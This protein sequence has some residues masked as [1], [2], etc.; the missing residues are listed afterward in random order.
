MLENVKLNFSPEFQVNEGKDS[1]GSWLSIGGLALEEGISKNKNKYTF[2]NLKEN[3]GREFKWLFGH[4]GADAEEHIVGLGKLS[5]SGSK[6][7]HEGKIRN[8][9]RH[10]DVVE[11][12]KD[13][14]LGPSI[15][16]TA[17]KIKHE[18]GVYTVEGLEIDGVGLV[19]FQGV[20]NASIDYAVAESFELIETEERKKTESEV[21]KMSEEE[22]KQPEAPAEAPAP[23]PEP[24]EAPKEEPKEEPAP[25]Q[26]NFSAEEIK[27]IREELNALKM[28]KKQSLVE[29]ILKVNSNMKS[30]DLMKESEEKLAMVLEYEGKLANKSSAVV[31][32]AQ[33][34]VAKFVEEKDG[35]Y[36]MSEGLYKKFNS[37]LRE[38]VR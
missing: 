30:E 2:N 23:A 24:V 5:Q 26:E 21:I 31:E 38:R 15:H 32:E 18:E 17:K 22:V 12:V 4:P 20:K 9:A 19:A 8:T 25:A 14:F 16:A 27:A 10:P 13:G 7:F 1:G 28:A 37:E 11:M 35:S 3:H 36:T 6:L 29:S 34:E 33:P